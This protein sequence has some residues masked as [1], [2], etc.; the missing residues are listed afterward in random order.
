MWILIKH[1]LLY[2]LGDRNGFF[3]QEVVTDAGWHIGQRQPEEL[4]V[5]AR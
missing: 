5:P 2:R 1:A 4:G 3:T